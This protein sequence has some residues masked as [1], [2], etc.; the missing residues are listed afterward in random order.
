MTEHL[1]VNQDTQKINIKSQLDVLNLINHHSISLESTTSVA[2]DEL[3][4]AHNSMG[5][6]T[7]DILKHNFAV[8]TKLA[9]GVVYRDPLLEL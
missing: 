7:T 9:N 8:T 3:D 6:F 1:D 4:K 5:W 2:P